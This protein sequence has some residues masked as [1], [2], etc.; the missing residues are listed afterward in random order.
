MKLKRKKFKISYTVYY[1]Q[2]YKLLNNPKDKKKKKG[3]LMKY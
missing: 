1:C 3:I 2:F